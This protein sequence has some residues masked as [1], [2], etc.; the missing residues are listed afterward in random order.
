MA[1]TDETQFER[2]LF[3]HLLIPSY[4]SALTTIG[5]AL[6]IVGAA[7]LT[8]LY[9]S[10]GWAATS[11]R[12][13]ADSNRYVLHN[14][15]TSQTNDGSSTLSAILLFIFWALVGLAVYFF[16]AGLFRAAGEAR[17][18][19]QEVSTYVHRNRDAII[20]NFAERMLTRIVGLCLLFLVV[21]LY[22]RELIPFGLTAG[23]A[24]ALAASPILSVV[25]AFCL[26]VVGGHLITILLRLV[27]LRPRLFS[28]DI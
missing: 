6:L 12:T 24:A 20:R 17:Q 5:A 25:S 8:R 1:E 9:W 4:L 3:H 2:R 26:L 10:T 7:L 18:L 19:E 11:V 21:T 16:V 23:R 14:W 22:L 28:A 13:I 27:A 15:G